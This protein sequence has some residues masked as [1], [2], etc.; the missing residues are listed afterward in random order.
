MQ[1]I[2]TDLP[3]PTD[4]LSQ[5]A[6]YSGLDV[7]TLFEIKDGL[8]ALMDENRWA[9]YNFEMELQSPLLAMSLVGIPVDE[10][11]RREM[12][13]QFTKEQTNLT[14][15]INKMLEAIGYFDYYRRMV[16]AEFS[17]YVDY[18]PLPSTWDEWLA[19]PLPTRRALK[20]AAPEAL[21]KYQKA[22]K[23][24][25]EP[26]NPVSPAQKLRLFYHFFGSPDNISAEGFFFSPPWLKLMVFTSTKLVTPKTSTLLPPTVR[27]LRR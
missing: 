11:A 5:L 9:I 6:L 23:E 12:T 13:I 19:L 17:T 8:S 7:L 20:E 26:F 27:H 3:V 14:L 21:D 24:F 18:S 16:I 2:R 10:A 4:T 15:L 22:I 1:I 25:S